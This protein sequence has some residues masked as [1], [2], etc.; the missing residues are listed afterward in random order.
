MRRLVVRATETDTDKGIVDFLFF[1]HYFYVFICG[2][3]GEYGDFKWFK[4][5]AYG[6]RFKCF[7]EIFRLMC[8]S[9]SQGTR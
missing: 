1:F 5:V 6:L 7:V 9:W 8:G 3:F 4:L 2:C